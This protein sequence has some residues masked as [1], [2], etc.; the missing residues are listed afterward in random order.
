MNLV[1]GIRTLSQMLMMRKT[2]KEVNDVS[3]G[4]AWIGCML[5]IHPRLTIKLK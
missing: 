2:K 4:R 5:Y 3:K 1:T